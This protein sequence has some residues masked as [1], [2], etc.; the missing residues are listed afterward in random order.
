[1]AHAASRQG[2]KPRLQPALSASRH[3]LVSAPRPFRSRLR[4]PLRNKR[5]RPP[6]SQPRPNPHLRPTDPPLNPRQSRS[7]TSSPDILPCREARCG[8]SRVRFLQN[9]LQRWEVRVPTGP[10]FA[11]SYLQ[12][13]NGRSFTWAFVRGANRALQKWQEWAPTPPTLAGFAAEVTGVGAHTSDPCRIRR[14]TPRRER[15]K[16]RPSQQRLPQSRVWA[17]RTVDFANAAAG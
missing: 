12:F 7:R 8:R 4:C 9:P 15:P 10:T 14:R 16:A 11:F 6:N 13:R 17:P 3:V 1:M 2:S 5:T